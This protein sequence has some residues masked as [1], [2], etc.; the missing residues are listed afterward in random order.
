VLTWS[1]AAQAQ[2]AQWQVP[3]D[4]SFPKTVIVTSSNQVI[5]NDL[6]NPQTVVAL[7]NPT[8]GGPMG[9]LVHRAEGYTLLI[10]NATSNRFE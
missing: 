9:L 7:T 4:Q 5:Y 6:F 3:V 10:W 2:L 1:E 8:L